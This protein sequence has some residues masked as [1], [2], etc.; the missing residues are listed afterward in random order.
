MEYTNDVIFKI[1]YKKDEVDIVTYGMHGKL[2]KIL[3]I[4]ENDNYFTVVMIVSVSVLVMDFF[5]IKQ[6]IEI[7]NLL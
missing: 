5:M 1:R 3:K 7:V 4:I 6:F 2:K